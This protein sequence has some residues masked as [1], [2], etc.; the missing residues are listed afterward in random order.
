MPARSRFLA[1]FFGLYCI[2]AGLVML[3]RGHG[4]VEVVAQIVHD[5]ALMYVLGVL[6]VMGGL[7]CVLAHNVWSGGPQF[8]LVTFMGWGTLVKGVLFMALPPDT[9]AKLF[10]QWLRYEDMYRVYTAVA[11]AIGAYLCWAGWRD[12]SPV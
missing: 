8:W 1:R 10:L 5:G 12:R 9:E 7:A 2:V 3:A 11:M 6:L 4:T